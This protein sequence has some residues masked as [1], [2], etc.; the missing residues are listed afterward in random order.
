MR[1][2]AI[3]QPEITRRNLLR[4]VALLPAMRAAGQTTGPD[5]F[6]SYTD[7]PRLLLLPARLKLLRRERDRRSLRWEQFETL[8]GVGTEFPE[9]GCD[10]GA[11]IPDRAGRIGR[12]A[13]GGL[14]SG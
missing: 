6:R 14:G 7:S 2:R 12:T 1:K 10:G 9:F 8:W 5:G 4:A 11:Q 3:K 13:G